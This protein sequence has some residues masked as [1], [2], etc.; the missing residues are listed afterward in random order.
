MKFDKNILLLYAVT[1]ENPNDDFFYNDVELALKNGVT[2]LQ[3]REKNLATEKFTERA[4][5]VKALCDKYNVAL[6]INDSIEV[7]IKSGADGIHVG[8]NDASAKDIKRRFSKNL[9]L[10]VSAHNVNEAL[11]A[12]E[13]GADYLG[14]GAAFAT[15]TKTDVDI[16][17]KQTM[18]EI[19]EN[20]KIPS[21]AIGGISY[22]NMD[23]LKDTGISGIAVVSAIFS[24]KNIETQTQKLLTKAK[25]IFKND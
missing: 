7:A 8:Q 11:L 4:K 5:K 17:N 14:L 15:N 6:I 10:G 24:Q 22:D 13:Q 2:C 12:Q 21:V 23:E 16:M 3:L 18:K 20:V 1:N 9:I 19:C 25:R